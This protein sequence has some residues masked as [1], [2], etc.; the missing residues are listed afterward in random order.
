MFIVLT[1]TVTVYLEVVPAEYTV[2]IRS[3]ARFSL[4]NRQVT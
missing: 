2:N 1:E 4:L 3:L